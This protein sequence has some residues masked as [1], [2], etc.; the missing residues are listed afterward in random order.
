MY[1]DRATPVSTQQHVVFF[2][3]ISGST[4]LYET[5][6]DVVA[7]QCIKESLARMSDEIVRHKG[8]VVE[9]IG[10]EL[11]AI[12]LTPLDAANCAAG[13]QADFK[14]QPTSTGHRIGIRIGFHYGPVEYDENNH[15]FGDSIN[16]AA[17]VVALAQAGQVVITDHSVKDI[18]SSLPYWFR[19]FSTT[20]VKGKAEPLTTVEL[21]WDHDEAT[22]IFDRTGRNEAPTAKKLVYQLEFQGRTIVLD[23]TRT[24]ITVGRDAQCDI[25][26]NSE[27]SSRLH[28]KI[29][30]RWG[31][32]VLIDHSTNGTYAV[33]SPG[34]KLPEG[35]NLRLHRREWVIQ[36]N[37]CIGFGQ[38]PSKD[39]Q[40]AVSFSEVRL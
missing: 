17:R 4:R 9:T 25:I 1:M 21:V 6:G 38:P 20:H 13:I 14:H 27:M 23:G 34:P 29:E 18:G 10:D 2:A 24:P 26:V 36:G 32:W 22:S 8:R 31:E 40:L 37:G 30:H 5:A 11:L 12:F 3:D 33:V 28:A 35:L 16:T 39:P 7:H 15:P 19:T